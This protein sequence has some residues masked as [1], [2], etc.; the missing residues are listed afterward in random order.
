[1]FGVSLDGPQP[2]IVMEYC[3]GGIKANQIQLQIFITILHLIVKS[4]VSNL[5]D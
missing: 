2:V 3:G 4:T 5:F 1:V